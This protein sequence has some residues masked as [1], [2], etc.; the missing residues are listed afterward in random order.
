MNGNDNN[1]SRTCGFKNTITKSLISNQMPLLCK[2]RIKSAFDK[3]GRYS[4][5]RVNESKAKVVSP[6]RFLCS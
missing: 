2:R 1:G 6:K 5:K 3:L 4:V